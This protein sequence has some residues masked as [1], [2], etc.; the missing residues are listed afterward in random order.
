MKVA[1]IV[2]PAL[3]IVQMFLVGVD[4]PYHN[5]GLLRLLIVPVSPASASH[6]AASHVP[7]MDVYDSRACTSQLAK[8]PTP[9]ALELMPM[10]GVTCSCSPGRFEDA[11]K[12]GK[13]GASATR[14]R[15]R[16]ETLP[17]TDVVDRK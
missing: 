10:S 14:W 5:K 8:T 6:A 9:Y 4:S 3:M 13:A 1:Q 12:A 2:R 17:S 7:A 16:Q 11:H 15:V